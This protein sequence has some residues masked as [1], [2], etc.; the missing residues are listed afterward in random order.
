MAGNPLAGFPT[1]PILQGEKRTFGAASPL[2]F[3]Q[4]LCSLRQFRAACEA[5]FILH[6]EF[7][8]F[9]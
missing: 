7:L 3:S 5:K 8:P 2:H 9:R 1:F 4:A 6:R